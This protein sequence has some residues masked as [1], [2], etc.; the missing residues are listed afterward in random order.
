[1]YYSELLKL[2]TFEEEEI[3]KE[4]P[5]I[6]KAFEKLEI[7]KE[8]CDRALNRIN[9]YFDADMLPIRKILGLWMRELVDLINAGDEGKKI[10][11]YSFPSIGGLG[12]ALSAASD[13]IHCVVPETLLSNAV[14]NIF[15]NE[16]YDPILEAGEKNGLSP[17]L[18]LCSLNQVR[19]GAIAEGIIPPPVATLTSAF[20]CDQTCQTDDM[21]KN[22]FPEVEVI[23]ID[24]CADSHWGE[25]PD[26][27]EERVRYLGK[28]INDAYARLEEV[29]DIK[30]PQEAFDRVNKF[31][32]QFWMAMNSIGEMQKND[33]YPL[34]ATNW[35]LF[36]YLGTASSCRVIDELPPLMN[37][38]VKELKRKVD[39]GK[40]PVEKGAPRILFPIPVFSDP[41][42]AH[43]IED[44]GLGY[45]VPWIC[46]FWPT[47]RWETQYT[48]F[49]EQKAELEMKIGLYNS[50]SGCSWRFKQM[51]K[52]WKLDGAIW[53]Y[54]FSCRPIALNSLMVKKDVEKDLGIPT[55]SLEVDCYDT[56][57]YN[58]QALRTRVETFAELLRARK[59]L[60]A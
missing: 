35:S 45:P 18:G 28:E 48:T 39:E 57:S 30:I 38:L 58:A 46:W 50:A 1:M 49:G 41:A 36:R 21:I 42:I 34:R 6:E 43:M 5:R 29:L 23:S 12:L 47:P 8:D 44:V 9:T 31:F 2:C 25:F 16:R 32:G 13:K 22:L 33:P 53:G 56:R 19:L 52:E 10:V 26:Y 51:V 60:A 11:Y 40:G 54:L 17:G 14:G 7:R 20:F 59:A 3:K 24:S 15:G 4:S 37:N 55:L 27:D